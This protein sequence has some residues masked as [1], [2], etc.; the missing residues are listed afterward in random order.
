MTAFINAG[1]PVGATAVPIT[2]SRDEPGLTHAVGALF[3]PPGNPGPSIKAVFAAGSEMSQAVLDSNK[4]YYWLAG[5]FQAKREEVDQRFR[6]SENIV[7]TFNWHF[8]GGDFDFERS[9]DADLGLALGKT[10]IGSVDVEVEVH[11]FLYTVESVKVTGTVSDLYDFDY[12]GA[13]QWPDWVRDA[14]RVQ[15]GYNTVGTGGRVYRSEVQ[16]LNSRCER[17]EGNFEF[18]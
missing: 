8:D 5:K 15:A 4:L 13:P 2:I 14:A 12:D 11:R 16:M 9:A 17:L 6:N 18:Q 1:T 3:Q 10:K 7:E